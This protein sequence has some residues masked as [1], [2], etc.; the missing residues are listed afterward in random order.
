MKTIPKTTRLDEFTYEW[1][2]AKAHQSN[3]ATA[4]LM[5]ILLRFLAQ[6]DAKL[7]KEAEI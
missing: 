1:L 2:E 5:A 3:M 6:E 7:P 4:T